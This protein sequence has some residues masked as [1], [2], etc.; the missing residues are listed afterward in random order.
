MDRD[1]LNLLRQQVRML[2]QDPFQ[3]LNPRFTVVDIVG[4]PL[5]NFGVADGEGLRERVGELLEDVGSTPGIWAATRT[6]SPGA[7]ASA[8]AWRAR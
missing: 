2:F 6:R 5:R 3:S 4:E 7:S 1:Q 8:S